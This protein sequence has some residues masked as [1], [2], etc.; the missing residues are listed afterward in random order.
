[1]SWHYL[2]EQA[3]A[4]SEAACT[5]GEQLPPLRSKTTH[6]AFYCNGKL[7]DGYLASLSGT[8]LK[9]STVGRG[10]E[11]LMSSRAASHARTSQ[12]Q[13][14]GRASAASGVAYGAKWHALSMR[15]DPDSFTL[16]THH[17]LFQEDLPLS[18]V[19]LPKWGMM[20]DG[21]L[22]QR[23]SSVR[24]TSETASGS[25]RRWATPTTQEITH[26]DIT[27]TAS[28]RRKAVGAGGSHSV[29]L[30]DQV[31]TW[32]T[33]S[34]T[35]HKGSGRNAT[36]RDR[37]DYAC[38]KGET[39]THSYAT[40]CITG[41]GGGSGNVEKANKLHELGVI[42][43][44]TR[45]SMRAGN[46]GQLNPDWVE[47]LMGWPV[48][49]TDLAPL[50][51]QAWGNWEIDP[52]LDGSTPRVT[53]SKSYPTPRASESSTTS[54]GRSTLRGMYNGGITG[55]LNPDWVEWLMGWPIGWTDLAP[56]PKQAWG[57]W[58][59]D[60]ALDGSTPRVTHKKTDRANRLKAVG[61]GQVPQVAARAWE[62]LLEG[63][64]KNHSC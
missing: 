38:E 15:F 50:P 5:A 27:L 58:E 45:R 35:D 34:A 47:W 20:Q 62:L 11:R 57:G 22:F 30:A 40:P 28:G 39:K 41:M 14:K 4:S 17:C 33:P 8:M 23:A 26:N 51:R 42:D 59:T 25:G 24:H 1:M 16:K 2:Q 36:A 19:T 43:E 44:D 37:L 46:G 64:C 3:G 7:T 18:S 63:K 31:Q 54:F 32:P 49:W 56:L 9:P 21:E 12:Q 10:E 55:Q 61:N 6:A 60:P 52:A 53:K 29:G 48:G 13:A